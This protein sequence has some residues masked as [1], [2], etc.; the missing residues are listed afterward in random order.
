MVYVL[1]LLQCLT[2]TASFMLALLA[3][4]CSSK[5]KLKL[6][7]PPNSGW[8]LRCLYKELELVSQC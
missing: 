2:A 6:K 7:V 8:N 4:S 3:P 5:F 1:H